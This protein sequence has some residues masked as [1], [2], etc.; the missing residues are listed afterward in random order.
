MRHGLGLFVRNQRPKL[1]PNQT[2]FQRFKDVESAA[3]KIQAAADMHG[4]AGYGVL[5][6]G[7]YLLLVRKPA[8]VL[9]CCG[10]LDAISDGKDVTL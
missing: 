9:G 7:D 3:E 1:S 2:A 6:E 10:G 5:Y 4:R 8:G